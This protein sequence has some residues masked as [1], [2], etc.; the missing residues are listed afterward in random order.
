MT[1]E[2]ASALDDFE[3]EDASGSRL[4]HPFLELLPVTGASVATVGSFLGTQTLAASDP[5]AERIDEVQFDLGEGPCWD[6]LRSGHAV[7]E[8][9]FPGRAVDRWPAFSE[10]LRGDELGGLF[11]F[12]L[13]VGTLRLGAIDLYTDEPRILS[14]LHLEQA[15]RLA[16]AVSKHVLRDAL[17][18]S[19]I[20]DELV[21]DRY[22]RRMVHQA[23]GVVLAQLKM[24]PDEAHLLIQGH[25]F[26]T[27]SSMRVVAE[28]ILAG[29]LVFSRDDDGIAVT[30][31]DE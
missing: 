29:R 1:R 13:R 9:D 18:K 30:E 11:A 7:L 20:D 4:Y 16:G 23:T 5:L 6:A 21:P 19:V 15:G 31:E 12:P 2:F 27:G 14:H 26:A 25:A 8:P 28:D 22:S 17:Q 24:T 3:H 10:A